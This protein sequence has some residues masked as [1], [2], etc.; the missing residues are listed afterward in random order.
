MEIINKTPE[1]TGSAML[2]LCAAPGD[3]YLNGHSHPECEIVA[4]IDGCFDHVYE[5]I[6]L[7]LIKGDVLVIPPN[8][9]HL[10]KSNRT[11]TNQAFIIQA[12]IAN[13]NYST[14]PQVYK[15]SDETFALF[16][17]INNDLKK[18]SIQEA[19]QFRPYLVAHQIPDSTKKLVEAWLYKIISNKRSPIEFSENQ[20][21]FTYNQAINFMNENIYRTLSLKDIADHCHVGTTTIKNTFKLYAGHG[22]ITHF[23]NMKINDSKK[24]IENG[25]SMS[26]ISDLYGFSSQA[27]YSQTF[28][29]IVGIT[30]IQYKK[31]Y[32]KKN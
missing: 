10:L 26:Y 17:I 21:A 8:T 23:L 28:K 31:R 1:I 11:P 6:I 25:K 7:T 30:P 27:Y 20:Y 13:I 18:M 4:I 22:V 24:M 32:Y 12:N 15:M 5:N 16:N 9:F 29:R 19:E 14:S 3:P 2:T